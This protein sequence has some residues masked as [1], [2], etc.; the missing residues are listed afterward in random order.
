MTDIQ[1]SRTDLTRAV[2]ALGITVPIYTATKRGRVIT[3]TTRMGKQ[4]YTIPVKA[5]SKRSS[6]APKS[7]T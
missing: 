1:I 2:K 6:T 7:T 4:T 3:I 5:K